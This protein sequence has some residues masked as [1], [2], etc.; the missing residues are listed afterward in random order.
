MANELA[1]GAAILGGAYL[2][3]QRGNADAAAPALAL[4]GS[5]LRA[6]T[7]TAPAGLLEALTIRV[8][9]PTV[10]LPAINIVSTPAPIAA[11][12]DRIRQAVTNALPT[13][14]V[15]R[16]PGPSFGDGLPVPPGFPDL[17]GTAGELLEGAGELVDRTADLL[18]EAR[19]RALAAFNDP[20]LS[21]ARDLADELADRA[22]EA[23]RIDNILENFYAAKDTA[24]ERVQDL[25]PG[26]DD[27][28]V[29]GDAMQLVQKAGAIVDFV[30]QWVGPKAWREGIAGFQFAVRPEAWLQAI[31]LPWQEGPG[32]TDRTRELLG[33]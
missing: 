22:W 4:P 13:V 18:A 16:P 20:D 21:A 1:I 33:I 27:F 3:S 12:V 8:E 17:T 30:D 24:L 25:A 28:G 9:A 11:A 19:D 14:N 6:P 7:V 31:R 2:L 23:A 26:L 29:V 15:P 32:I 5:N 10:T